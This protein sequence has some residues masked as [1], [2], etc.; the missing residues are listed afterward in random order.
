MEKGG[1]T[2]IMKRDINLMNDMSFKRSLQNYATGFGNLEQ[3]HWLG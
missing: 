3:N 2:V 1:W